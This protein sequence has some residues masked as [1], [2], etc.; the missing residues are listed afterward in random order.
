MSVAALPADAVEVAPRI[1]DRE[2]VER[3]TALDAGQKNLEARMDA[4]ERSL[5]ARID[6]L[7]AEMNRR[8]DTLQWMLGVFITVALAI[9]AAIAKNLLT[10]N[11]AQAAQE[12][13]NESL[14][15]EIASLKETD[16]R[17]MDQIKALIEHLKP[18][19]GSL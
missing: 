5:N 6:D 17:L 8:F 1:T 16:L 3:L 9:F 10:L 7:R 11:R 19:K 18:P 13:I 4:L 15:A 14:K 12:R 2:I